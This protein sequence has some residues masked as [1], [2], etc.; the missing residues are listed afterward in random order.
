MDQWEEQ[1]RRDEEDRRR[2]DA[3]DQRRRDDEERRRRDADDQR[4]R[5]DESRRDTEKHYDDK[6]FF[7]RKAADEK[8][9]RNIEANR[10]FNNKEKAEQHAYEK[11]LTQS[12]AEHRGAARQDEER[13]AR[14]ADRKTTA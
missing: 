7:D 6:A 10:Y 2:R 8:L 11:K 1:R 4:R 14:A 12:E 3:D 9:Q 5:D 13:L